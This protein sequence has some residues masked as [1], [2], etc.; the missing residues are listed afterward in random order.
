MGGFCCLKKIVIRNLKK[1][2]IMLLEELIE[3]DQKELTSWKIIYSHYRRWR[4]MGLAALFF[5]VGF[6]F[7]LALFLSSYFAKAACILLM[8]GILL[9][10]LPFGKP[11]TLKILKMHARH[12]GLST[13]D[14]WSHRNVIIEKIRLKK[15]SEFIAGY[16]NISNEKI[17]H[18]REEL[19]VEQ[20]LPRHQNRLIEIAPP[21]ISIIL[22]AFFAAVTAV[23][24]FF[25]SFGTVVAFFK[26]YMGFLLLFLLLYWYFDRNVLKW[27]F[28]LRQEKSMRLR[29]VLGN[30]LAERL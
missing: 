13:A 28:E 27:L 10:T 5:G 9:L 7:F 26:P 19:T 8:L 12:Y 14:L 11:E 18:F 30:Y 2:Q 22:A 1:N 16:G 24:D 3:F 15:L 23:K 17:I 21:L 6:A 29:R 4:L 25:T 20:G